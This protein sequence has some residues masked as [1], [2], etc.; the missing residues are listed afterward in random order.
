MSSC[1]WNV[2]VT[3]GRFLEGKIVRV[4]AFL[5]TR[6][7]LLTFRTGIR[8][9]MTLPDLRGFASEQTSNTVL[10]AFGLSGYKNGMVALTNIGVSI[11]SFVTGAVF[12][13]QLGNLLGP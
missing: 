6:L 7:L 1:L 12:T 11:A 8:D 4:D 10:L 13:G 3:S 5:E 2:H 9:G